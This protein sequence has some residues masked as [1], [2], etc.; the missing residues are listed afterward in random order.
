M[1]LINVAVDCESNNGQPK[2]APLLTTTSFILV[3]VNI[4]ILKRWVKSPF[5]P[6]HVLLIATEL[7]SLPTLR[8]LL[9]A[10]VSINTIQISLPCIMT[11]LF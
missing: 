3:T 11:S 4:R 6:C 2:S 7:G 1:R 5:A 8:S 9:N 10:G